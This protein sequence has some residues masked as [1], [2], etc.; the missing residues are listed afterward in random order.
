MGSDGQPAR[1][2]VARRAPCRGSG[3]RGK[4]QSFENFTASDH[5]KGILCRRLTAVVRVVFS[6]LIVCLF[7]C[8]QTPVRTPAGCTLEMVQKLDLNCSPEDPC[9][10]YLELSDVETVADRIVLAGNI[11]TPSATLESLLLVSDDAGKT[12]NEAHARILGGSLTDIQFLDFET[13]W[14]SGHIL[15]PDARDPFFL[16]SSDGGKSWRRRP[17]YSEPKT[18]AIDRFRFTSKTSGQMMVDR[19]QA[20]ENGLRYELWESLTG[21]ES[22]NVRQV[23]AKPMPFPEGDRSPKPLRIRADAASKSFRIE[24]QE[25]MQWQPLASFIVFLGQCQPAPPEVKEDARPPEVEIQPVAPEK[26]AAP[27]PSLKGKKN[28]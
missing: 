9:P 22:W 4:N 21:G 1:R 5:S 3:R 2:D 10:L 15:H 20:G 8:A 19:A 28:K 18:G 24:R 25:G 26:P 12:W 14:I 27:P 23:D 6:T 16:I 7:A 11:H 17:V 13:G